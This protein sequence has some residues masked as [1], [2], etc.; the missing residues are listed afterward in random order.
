MVTVNNKDT[1]VK[2]II[3]DETLINVKMVP[4]RYFAILGILMGL[5][6]ETKSKKTKETIMALMNDNAKHPKLKKLIGMV[7]DEIEW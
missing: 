7:K 3:D 2:E 5:Y 4:G 6:G 1:I